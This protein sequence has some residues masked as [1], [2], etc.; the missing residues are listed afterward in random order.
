[1]KDFRKQYR[2]KGFSNRHNN[3]EYSNQPNEPYRLR[4]KPKPYHNN[5]ITQSEWIEGCKTRS[6]QFMYYICLYILESVY[7][8]RVELYHSSPKCFLTRRKNIFFLSSHPLK[9]VIFILSNLVYL[10]NAFLYMIL[11]TQ[12]D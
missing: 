2:K 5:K 1:M 10:T 7:T 6:S 3:P 4:S 11:Y 12:A 9:W 8:L